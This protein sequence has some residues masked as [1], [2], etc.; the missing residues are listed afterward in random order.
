M[1][2]PEDIARNA[3]GPA[4]ETAPDNPPALNARIEGMK[5][6]VA[7]M[8]A[9]VTMLATA[10][11]LAIEK[12]KFAMVEE[13]KPFSVRDY[14]PVLIAE[15]TVDG[16]RNASA[17]KAFRILAAYIFGDNSAPGGGKDKIAMTAPVTQSA[18]SE[19]IAMTAPV[20]QES[21]GANR[22]TV[23]FTMPSKY[24]VKTLPKPVDTRIAIREVPARRMAVVTFSGVARDASIAEETEKLKA[25]MAEQ[26][27]TARG[28]PEIAYYDPPFKPG[29]LRRNEVMIPVR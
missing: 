29:F 27:L 6:I 22:W 25:F 1:H 13:R 24:T 19:K 5:T 9:I 26:G 10:A 12:P 3:A 28:K 20:T 11:G 23:A 16:D 15:V 18:K 21:V 17:N 8:T 4:A 14:A 7:L 2:R